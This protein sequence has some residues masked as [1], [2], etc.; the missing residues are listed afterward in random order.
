MLELVLT[1]LVLVAPLEH[2]MREEPRPVPPRVSLSVSSPQQPGRVERHG[3]RA[4]RIT[5]LQFDTVFP[6]R[7][8]GPHVLELKIFTPRGHLYQVLTVP[9]SGEGRGGRRRRVPGNPRFLLEREMRFVGAGAYHVSARL[10]VAGTWITTNSLYGSWRVE[11]HVDGAE[12]PS[13]RERFTI[14]P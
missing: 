3:F 2:G 13:G 6:R 4:S 8:T 7:L 12:W 14:Q 11:A 5:E 9:F 1:T 10:P